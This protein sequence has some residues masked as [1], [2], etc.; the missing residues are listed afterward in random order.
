MIQTLTVVFEIAIGAIIA[1]VAAEA[2]IWAFRYLHL[3]VDELAEA[4]EERKSARIKAENLAKWTPEHVKKIDAENTA[5]YLDKLGLSH[6]ALAGYT[7]NHRRI[8]KRADGAT[9]VDQEFGRDKKL[10]VLREYDEKTNYPPTK[11][12]EIHE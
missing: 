4:Y 12:G 10:S 1:I 9:V 11:R 7:I 5:A 8:F 3:K 6:W 2:F